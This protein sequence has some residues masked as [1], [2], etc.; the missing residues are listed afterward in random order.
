VKEAHV[1]D[2]MSQPGIQGV[3]VAI[4]ADNPAETAISIY[5][6]QGVNHPLI[7]AMI[8]GVRTKIFEGSRFKAY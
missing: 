6:I 2:L 8:D 7:P 1:A 3:G 4:S 5:V